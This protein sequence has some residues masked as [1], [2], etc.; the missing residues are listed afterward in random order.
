M[1]K[2]QW[3]E[4]LYRDGRLYHDGTWE[5]GKWYE[6]LDLYGNR[7]IA[8]MKSDAIDHFFPCSERI[9]ELHVVAFREYKIPPLKRIEITNA[10]IL[11]PAP[12]VDI[13]ADACEIVAKRMAYF[14]QQEDDFLI[15]Q[16]IALAKSE[17]VTHLYLIDKEFVL[18]AIRNEMERRNKEDLKP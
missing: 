6:W 10:D 14:V 3:H 7:E 16:I 2:E 9:K 13:F 15:E 12:D 18:T 4:C 5:E 11:K 8:R 1:K 17:G